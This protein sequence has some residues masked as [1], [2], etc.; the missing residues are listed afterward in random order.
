MSSIRNKAGIW[1]NSQVFREEAEHFKKYGY[2]CA[3]PWGSSAWFEYWK[4]QKKRC[5]EGISIG[6]ARITGNH[7][8]YLNFC[9]I[10]RLVEVEKK[11]SKGYMVKR[12]I[13]EREFADFYD[14]DYY[15]FSAIQEAEDEGKHMVV[16][17]SRGKGYSF[18]GASMLCRN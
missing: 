15:Y 2:Y 18:K 3:D 17:K 12:R 13:R 6:G 4:E 8:F 1:I 16:L 5:V 10:M 9:P 14:Y 11:N 7:Y